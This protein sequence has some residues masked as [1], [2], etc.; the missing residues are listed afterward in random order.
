MKRY[1]DFFEPDMRGAM[2]KLLVRAY[3]R[4]ARKVLVI[5]TKAGSSAVTGTLKKA[6]FAWVEKQLTVP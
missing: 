2:Q 5:G 6:A 1:L 4:G 3:E